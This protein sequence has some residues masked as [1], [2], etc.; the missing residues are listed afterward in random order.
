MS[1]LSDENLA[2]LHQIVTTGDV[3]PLRQ[4]KEPAE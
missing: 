1:T 4:T 2:M 3:E